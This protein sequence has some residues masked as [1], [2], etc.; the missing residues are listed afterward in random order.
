MCNA[1][2]RYFANDLMVQDLEIKADDDLGKTIYG[3]GACSVEANSE[4]VARASIS[5]NKNPSTTW[6]PAPMMNPIS[7]TSEPT[8]IF[9]TRPWG[10]VQIDTRSNEREGRIQINEE[11]ARTPS[12]RLSLTDEQLRRVAE[13]CIGL[14]RYLRQ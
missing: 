13:F 6:T 5:L 9:D 2:S 8:W 3:F 4:M 11:H 7:G 14:T 1:L 12:G 10:L